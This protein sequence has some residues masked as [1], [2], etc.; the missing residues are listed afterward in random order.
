MTYRCV[1]S[2]NPPRLDGRQPGLAPAPPRL[3]GANIGDVKTG[4]VERWDEIPLERVTEMVSRKVFV[5]D[6]Q[7]MVQVHLL[8]GAHVP[9]HRHESE[10]MIYVLQGALRCVVGGQA[11][12]VEA[13]DVL[14][15]PSGVRH[16]A[17]ALE[18]TFQMVVFGERR[19]PGAV[20]SEPGRQEP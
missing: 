12:A 9:L 4:R 14:H 2:L 6:R 10:Q 17:E 1:G 7:V 15:V 3:I 19:I 8:C 13:G 20:R 11:V 16:Q 18:D 5:G